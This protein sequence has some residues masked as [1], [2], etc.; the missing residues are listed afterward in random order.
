[1]KNITFDE[2]LEKIKS[3]NPDTDLG[4]LQK[5]F[6]FS[7]DVHKD[8]LRL[9]GDP[10]ITHP[11]NVAGILADLEQD[12]STIA[13]A[14]LHDTIEDGGI[15]KDELISQFGEEITRLVEGVTKLGQ[16]TFIS[17]EERQAENFRKMFLAMGEDIRI[18]II[19]LA[20][21]LHNMQ[22]IE[23]LPKEKQKETSL[24]TKDIFAPL[25]H[26]LGMWRLMWELEDLSF[27]VLEPEKFKEIRERVAEARLEREA[28]VEAFMAEL[29]GV[30]SKVGITAEIRG[31]P[32]HFYSIYRK[33]V[34]QNVE[35]D[36]IYD[37]IAVRIIIET[38]KECY[39]ILGLIHAAWRP[40][41]GRFRDYI[42]MPKS[43]G[44]Q[45]L[46]TTVVG[47]GGRPVEI[48][49]R[50]N[51]MHRIAEYGIAAH[52]RYKEGTTDR[53]LDQKMGWLRRF[54]DWQ[55]EL[56]DAKDFIESLKIDLFVDEVFVFTPKGDVFPLPAAS[57]PV[58]FAYRIHTEVGHRCTGA[59]VNGKIVP[60]DNKLENGD[61]IEIITGKSDHPSLDWL[62]FVKTPAARAKVKSFFKRQ[63][64]DENVSRG[65]SALEDE[66]GKLKL[67]P[68]KV[69]S[70]EALE[71]LLKDLGF[72][73]AD[74]LYAAIGYGERS[75]YQAAKRL[76]GIFEKTEGIKSTEEE[77]FVLPPPRRARKKKGVHGIRVAG[78][79][80][81]LVRFSK[82]CRPLPGEDIIGF[83]TKGRGVTVHRSDCPNITSLGLPSGRVVKVEWDLASEI[84]YPVEIEVEA[85]DRVGVLKDILSEIA[86]IKT[87]VSAADVRTKR[88][89][90]AF[91][92]LV[93]DVKDIDHLTEAITAVQKVSDVYDVYR[94]D[95]YKTKKLKGKS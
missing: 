33:M 1:M 77:E 42:A 52:W 56:K 49:I 12:P 60:L 51:E 31:R 4:I 40:I 43:N 88:G 83:V 74:E 57:T 75:A 10:Y 76:R 47:T 50:T 32:K 95:I 81:I 80:N 65:R 29:S 39:T 45:S 63:K 71:A 24:E 84:L 87:N 18:I 11:L 15:S 36:E 59:R 34:E 30:I 38:V 27:A 37:L 79:A 35:F 53:S 46:H 13:A 44:Y 62:N 90:T 58:D 17:K 22:T 2:L 41:P 6:D 16:L 55:G 89:T 25:A 94:T 8:H 70:E 91:I 69:F 86:E 54:L 73:T 26:R 9:S 23:F 61:I 7:K 5:A 19:K 64:M 28:Y 93:V 21:R 68:S 72:L 20:D 48:Q 78:L 14:L 92:K 85:F 82:C 66:I 67:D 3:F